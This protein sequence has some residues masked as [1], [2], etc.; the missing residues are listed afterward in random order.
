MLVPATTK[1][2]VTA[3]YVALCNAITAP[4]V[5]LNT[6]MLGVVPLQIVAVVFVIAKLGFGF[7]NTVAVWVALGKQLPTIASN[8]Y[9]TVN[10]PLLV[11]L[12]I[13]LSF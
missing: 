9:V 11:L 1:P 8:T 12:K 13:S 4:V 2:P 5:G 6:L 7:T 10:G 3:P